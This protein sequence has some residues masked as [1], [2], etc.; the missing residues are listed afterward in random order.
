MVLNYTFLKGQQRKIYYIKIKYVLINIVEVK[1][2][3]HYIKINIII[4][5]WWGVFSKNYQ[6]AL[7]LIK[8]FNYYTSRNV[9][10][11]TN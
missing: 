3:L 11:I 9:Y 1:M 6:Y 10:I 8:N 7:I 5:F 2:C 4:K